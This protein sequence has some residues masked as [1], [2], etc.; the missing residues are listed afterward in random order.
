[1]QDITRR[2]WV[3]GSLSG[4]ALLASGAF[5]QALRTGERYDLVIKGGEV[6]DP[7]RKLRGV[8]DIGIRSAVIV[9]VEADIPEKLAVQTIDARGKLVTPGLI[10]LHA[11][12]YPLGSAIG[13][14]ADELAPQTATT[15]FVSAGDAGAN[16]FGALKHYIIG[17][18]RSRIYAF[19]H[20]SS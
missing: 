19:I 1:M 7:S 13:L 14:P 2:N 3:V 8:R 10:D 11:H 4:A 17:Q 15:T 18:T 6:L 16:N 5:A 20:I 9:A 12:V